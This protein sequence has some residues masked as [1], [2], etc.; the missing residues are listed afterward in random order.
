M[1][2]A[3]H[4]CIPLAN[5]ETGKTRQEEISAVTATNGKV[6]NEEMA[7]ESTETERCS[8][9]NGNED[10]QSSSCVVINVDVENSAY[11]YGDG[12]GSSVFSSKTCSVEDISLMGVQEEV[13]GTN[14]ARGCDEK[15]PGEAGP[16]AVLEGVKLESE[17]VRG[18]D[19]VS[20]SVEVQK[21]SNESSSV[22]V[23]EEEEEVA[24]LKQA[25][26]QE[27]INPRGVRFMSQE[28]GQDGE[29]C[30]LMWL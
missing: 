8:S 27:Y 18:E 30:H 25:E 13:K 17:S 28:V 24:G 12:D 14:H 3:I 7:E 1:Q 11:G 19:S 21:F 22:S 5:D 9:I 16:E 2:G 6:K 26:G 10:T 20:A 4:Q 15:V 29:Y 23:E